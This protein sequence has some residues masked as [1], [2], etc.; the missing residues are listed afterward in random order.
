MK[1]I[2]IVI[3]LLLF[4]M[5]AKPAFAYMEVAEKGDAEA[6]AGEQNSNLYRLNAQGMLAVKKL[7]KVDDIVAKRQAAGQAVILSDVNDLL[8]SD[9][10]QKE[11][12]DLLRI[13]KELSQALTNPK[14]LKVTDV[15][16]VYKQIGRLPND[17]RDEAIAE[18]LRTDLRGKF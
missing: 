14:R 18:K 16:S 15:V 17:V 2:S 4:T 7:K 6:T 11:K 13:T 9:E 12:Q 5:P 3:L 8:A 1:K 10:E